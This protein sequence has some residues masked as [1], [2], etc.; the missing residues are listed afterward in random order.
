MDNLRLVGDDLVFQG[1][2]VGTLKSEREVPAT[3]M[4]QLRNRLGQTNRYYP[5]GFYERL[6]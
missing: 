2:V 5:R 1:V 6:V 3:I 4:E